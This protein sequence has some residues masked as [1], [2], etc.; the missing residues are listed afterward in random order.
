MI[1]LEKMKHEKCHPP[2]KKTCPCNILPVPP[3]PPPPN[4]NFKKGWE[5]VPTMTVTPKGY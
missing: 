3:P 4:Q 2:F 5:G 1:N